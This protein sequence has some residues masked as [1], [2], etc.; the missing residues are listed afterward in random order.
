MM[1]L[2][3]YKS[4]LALT[5]VVGLVA[6]TAGVG[7]ARPET[8]AGTVSVAG[9][10]REAA[11]QT[12]DRVAQAEQSLWTVIQQI[13]Q[14]QFAFDATTLTTGNVS[15]DGYRRQV[16]PLLQADAKILLEFRERFDA[17]YGT[18]MD[19]LDS[20]PAAF[21]SAAREYRGFAE[22]EPNEN[23]AAKYEE[24]A[25]QADN[26]ATAMVTR[27]EQ[28]QELYR[29]ID[30]RTRFVARSTVFLVRFDEFLALVPDL[31]SGAELQH[32]VE[33]LSEFADQLR[34]ASESFRNVSN[35]LGKFPLTV[36]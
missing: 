14:L 23:F 11:R 27:Q 18:Y 31:D 24:L 28:M 3:Q 10:P 19:A 32:Y 34:Q 36:S 20:A 13:Q 4:M 17:A 2:K 6:P 15:A 30:E 16:I 35:Q 22:A 9:N 1:W 5:A 21:K 8:S 29:E 12:S 33:K 7:L 26:F 25:D